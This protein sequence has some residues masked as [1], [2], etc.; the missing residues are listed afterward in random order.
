ME[1]EK[2]LYISVQKKLMS[3]LNMAFQSQIS[4]SFV[5]FFNDKILFEC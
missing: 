2:N 1:M 5:T 4:W 3:I